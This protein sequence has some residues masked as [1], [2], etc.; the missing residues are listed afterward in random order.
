MR[1]GTCGVPPSHVSISGVENPARPSIG[2]VVRH[3]NIGQS[4]VELTSAMELVNDFAAFYPQLYTKEDNLGGA[5][6]EHCLCVLLLR[7][8]SDVEENSLEAE[9]REEELLEAL[10]QLRADKAPGP[11]GFPG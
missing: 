2:F 3:S 8:L 5:D 11:K 6:V 7:W 10:T 4:E 1:L 9:L